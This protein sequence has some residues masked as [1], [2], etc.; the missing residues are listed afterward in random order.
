MI[1]SASFHNFLAAALDLRPPL[2]ISSVQGGDINATYR[3]ECTE[4]SSLFLKV[5]HSQHYPKMLA[6]EA[7][8]LKFLAADQSFRIPSV[9]AILNFEKQDILVLEYISP[10]PP[11]GDFFQVF[12]AR[13]AQL[14]QNRNSQFG[15]SEDNYIGSLDQSNQARETWSEFYASQRIEPLCKRALDDGLLSSRDIKTSEELLNRLD[16]LL[17]QEAPSLVHGDLWSGNFLCGEDNQPILVDPAIYYGH[18]EMDLAMMKLFGGFPQSVFQAYQEHYPTD[19]GLEARLPL[20]QWY[21]L[22][23]HLNLFG[24]SYYTSV[25]AI[26]SRFS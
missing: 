11:R 7:R 13:L 19:Q 18:R 9:K 20:Y 3:V 16:S 8:A 2:K 25:R 15:W 23:V 26:L 22:L 21:P 4:H 1:N 14:H 10:R 5:N 24:A 12:G 6:K 17:P